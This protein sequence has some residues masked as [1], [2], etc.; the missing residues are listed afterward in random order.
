MKYCMKSHIFTAA[1]FAGFLS[2]A[3]S[4]DQPIPPTANPSRRRPTHHR[5]EF[6][7]CYHVP[8]PIEELRRPEAPGSDLGGRRSTTSGA[9]AG[10]ATSGAAAGGARRLEQ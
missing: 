8:S 9:T 2:S 6:R 5:R 10:G 4:N 1:L 7:L 3:S